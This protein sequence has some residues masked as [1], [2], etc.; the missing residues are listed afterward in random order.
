MGELGDTVSKWSVPGSW[1]EHQFDSRS[2]PLSALRT[3]QIVTSGITQPFH[4]PQMVFPITTRSPSDPQLIAFPLRSCRYDFHILQSR[5]LRHVPLIVTLVTL[6]SESKENLQRTNAICWSVLT[7]CS[8][9]GKLLV[10]FVFD[11]LQETSTY[12]VP[13]YHR[14]HSHFP[15]LRSSTQ[16]QRGVDRKCMYVVTHL[17]FK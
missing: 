17:G 8:I 5:D 3:F 7:M 15:P 16:R 14:D 12:R 10:F 2:V 13:R 9:C 4:V 1:R 11:I 6:T